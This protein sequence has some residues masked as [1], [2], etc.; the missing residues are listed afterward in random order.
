MDELKF[1]GSL[2][3]QAE[4]DKRVKILTQA[5]AGTYQAIINKIENPS[6][7]QLSQGKGQGKGEGGAVNEEEE[8]VTKSDFIRQ[9]VYQFLLMVMIAIGILVILG[10]KGMLPWQDQMVQ[11]MVKKRME[12]AGQKAASV[13]SVDFHSQKKN[14]F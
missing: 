13:R 1:N 6:A 12:Q 7:P 10:F 8:R 14:E 3:E 11:R 9:C 2:Q 4:D 5:L